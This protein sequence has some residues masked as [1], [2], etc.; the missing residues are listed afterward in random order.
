MGRYRKEKILSV[1]TTVQRIVVKGYNTKTILLEG[2]PKSVFSKR[3]FPLADEMVH[4]LFFYRNCKKK[5]VIGNDKPIEPRTYQ[6]KF[7]KYLQLAG[8]QK[9]NFHIL[10][11]TFA[12]NCINSGMDIKSIS[13]IL[14]HSD[15][16]TTL[17][18]YMLPL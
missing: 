17:N 16:K 11:H 15:V 7:Q 1:N 4:L 18:C 14:G 6:N 3:E 5:Y 2:K 9:K 10:R 8:I 12:T 13:E